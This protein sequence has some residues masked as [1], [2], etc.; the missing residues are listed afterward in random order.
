M[1]DRFR[2]LKK[3]FIADKQGFKEFGSEKPTQSQ[4]SPWSTNK[5]KPANKTASPFVKENQLKNKPEINK[6]EIKDSR[7]KNFFSLPREQPKSEPRQY[8]GSSSRRFSLP[9]F[10]APSLPKAPAGMVV[11]I[12][13]IIISVI[14]LIG[15]R[16]IGYGFFT[17]L[18]LTIIQALFFLIMINAGEKSIEKEVKQTLVVMIFLLDTFLAQVILAAWPDGEWKNIFITIHV[19]AWVVL[20]V[21][22]FLMGVFDTLGAGEKLGKPGW[23]LLLIILGAALFFLF[24]III[25]SPLAKQDETHAEYYGIAKAQIVKIAGTLEETKNVWYD[26]FT[27]TF[28]VLG[29]NYN[30]NTC[31][32]DKRI[33]RYCKNNVPGATEQQSCFQEQ[34]RLAQIGGA[35][36]VEGTVS[37][38]IKQIT[39]VDLKVDEFFP[40]KTTEPRKLYPVSLAVQNPRQQTFLVSISCLFT[41]QKNN[42]SGVVFLNGQEQNQVQI[43]EKE[44]QVIVDCQPPAD[45]KGKYTLSY[46]AT[47]SG[48]QTFSFLKRAFISEKIDAALRKQIEADNFKTKDKTSQGPAEFALLNF[49][50]GTGDGSAPLVLAEEPVSFSFSVADVGGGEVLKVNSYDFHGLWERGFS[51]DEERVGDNDCLQGG[52]IRLIAAQT[53]KREASELKRC[54]LNLPPDLG[55]L[56]E[57][58]FKVETFVADL[59]YD[60]KLTKSIPIEVT[61]L[62]VIS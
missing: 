36:T 25:Q 28:G 53:K 50:F 30:Y 16:F 59:N 20:A 56:N 27:C 12:L 51:A 24:P 29:G 22:L 62:E 60:Y 8:V 7:V 61:P 10:N 34:K 42:L 33:V 3:A 6:P 17:S 21:V 41:Q 47:L 43:N 15:K 11:Y 14:F 18:S 58:E 1:V 32:E 55:Q 48:M 49:K 52:E 37:D 44:Q 40:K 54:Y 4:Q 2:L 23:L 46:T 5:E 45:L 57:K 13:L 19:F 38:A 39:K 35:A 9:S 31:I 26:Y